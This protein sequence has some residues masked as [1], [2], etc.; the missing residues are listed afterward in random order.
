MAQR[1]GIST[2]TTAQRSIE[3]A[4]KM[5]FNTTTSLLEYYDGTQWKSID[6]PPVVSSIDVTDVDST[7]GGNQTFVITGSN[8]SSTITSVTFVEK[9]E[10]VTTIV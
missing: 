2:G 1:K 7:A 10:P 9:L 4:G 8:F 6:S 5:R 3:E